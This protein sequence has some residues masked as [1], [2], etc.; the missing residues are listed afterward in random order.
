[1]ITCQKCLAV[2]TVR[3]KINP[4][5]PKEDGHNRLNHMRPGQSQS[6][7]SIITPKNMHSRKGPV[8]RTGK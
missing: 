5:R 4:E 6:V 8:L 7:I 3:G 1:M 2:H